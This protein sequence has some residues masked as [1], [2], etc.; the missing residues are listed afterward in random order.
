YVHPNQ[1][2]YCEAMEM[3]KSLIRDFGVPANAII[4]EPH[5]RHTTTNL[6]NAARLI[7]RDG[8]PF[9]RKALVTTDSFQSATIESEAFAKRCEQ[10]LG[11]QP[12]KI[13]KR[14]SA[15]DLELAPRME[16][17]QINPMDPLDP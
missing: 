14:V 16:S 3:K 9:E 12:G 1:T 8:I 13:L 11:Y 6:R 4:I 17:L 15:F 5:A 7:Y 10:E 2:P